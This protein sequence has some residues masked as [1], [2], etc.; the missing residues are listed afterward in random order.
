MEGSRPVLAEL[1]ALVGP[2]AHGTPRRSVVGWDTN[3]LAMLLAVFESRCGLAIG[4]RDIYLSVTGGYRVGEPAGDLA[5]A[6]ALL[7]AATGDPLPENCIFFGEVALSGAIRPVAR[8][9]VRLKEAERLGFKR[10]I[11]PEGVSSD[12][13]GLKVTPVKRLMD[14]APV[15]GMELSE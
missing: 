12:G 9:E 5:A 15:L 6:A 7:S 4:A 8:M 10:A 14:L 13:K 3:R 11:T 2:P 1:Q